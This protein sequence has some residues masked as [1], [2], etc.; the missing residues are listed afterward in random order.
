VPEPSIWTLFS[1]GLI[2]IA[3]FARKFRAF[4]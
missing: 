1:V 2:S 4:K 3:L